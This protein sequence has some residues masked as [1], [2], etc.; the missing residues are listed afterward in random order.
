VADS[1]IESKDY[2]DV[3]LYAYQLLK[4][5]QDGQNFTDESLQSKATYALIGTIFS[6][7]EKY[8]Q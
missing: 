4:K 8:I 3:A 5:A 1:N 7:T 6:A 2:F